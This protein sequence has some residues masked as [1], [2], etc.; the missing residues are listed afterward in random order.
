MI[1]LATTKAALLTNILNPTVCEKQ[2]GKRGTAAF[3]D[4]YSSILD[5]VR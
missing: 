1:A 4:A 2:D 3:K 5:R